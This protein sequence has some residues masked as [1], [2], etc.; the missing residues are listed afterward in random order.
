MFFSNKN[1]LAKIN[2][3]DK[4]ACWWDKKVSVREMLFFFWFEETLPPWKAY[5][6]GPGERVRPRLF[7]ALIK[8]YALT[9]TRDLLCRSQT[10]CHHAA[11]LK[12]KKCFSYLSF[13][14]SRYLLFF[15]LA[16]FLLNEGHVTKEIYFF[17]RKNLKNYTRKSFSS[18]TKFT[19]IFLKK[20]K[21]FF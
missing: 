17:H 8:V 4:E 13:K 14:S 16:F 7:Q 1:N 6:M 18:L 10:L 15:L 5:F 19:I 3:K 2:K 11:P 21:L 9:R 12:N 20:I